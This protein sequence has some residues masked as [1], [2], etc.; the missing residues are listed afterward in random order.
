MFRKPLACFVISL[1]PVCPA[2]LAQNGNGS[3]LGNGVFTSSFVSDGNT[4]PV[5]CIGESMDVTLNVLVRSRVFETPSGAT[6]IID[7]WFYDGT[8]IGTISGNAWSVHGT[9]PFRR[10]HRQMQFTD[11]V[12]LNLVYEPLDG[13]SKLKVDFLGHFTSDA[14]GVRRVSFTDYSFTC[15]GK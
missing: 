2:A 12:K 4:G 9:Y 11:G 10:N 13:Q 15:R 6:H 7:N 14:N 5:E 3:E 8:A 1:L